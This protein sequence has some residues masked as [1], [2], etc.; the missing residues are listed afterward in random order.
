MSFSARLPAAVAFA[1][2]LAAALASGCQTAFDLER[3]RGLFEREEAPPVPVLV[4][5]PEPTL[6]APEGL[7]ATTG[8][9]RRV[10]LRWDPVLDGDVAGYVVERAPGDE[11]PFERVAV[12]PGRFQTAWVDRGSDLA[13]KPDRPTGGTQGLGD[14]ERFTYRVRAFDRQGALAA[15]SPAV[16]V[17]TAPPPAPPE[18]VH[19]YSHL[20]R[21]VAVAW[22]PS[23]DPTTAGYVI[24]RSPT[25]RGDFLPVGR[26]EGRYRTTF[27]DRN[28]G[29]L[30]VFYYRVASVNEA[31]AEGPPS[32]AERGVTKPVPLPPAGVHLHTREVGRNVLGWRPNVESDLAG[33]RL[34]RRREGTEAFQEVASLPADATEAEDRGVAAGERVAYAVMAFDRDGLESAPS[35]PL[36]VESLGFG[37]QAEVE[38]GDVHLRWDPAAQAPFA[39]TRILLEGLRTRELGRVA[40]EGFVDRRPPPGRRRYRLIGVRPD[41]RESPL[42]AVVEV[43]VPEPAEAD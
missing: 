36:V 38:G 37:L 9:L 17:A 26:V 21:R 5:A 33:Y 31:G 1:A 20:P 19:V 34:L 3:A 14:G 35:D 40:S 8:E 29:D 13:A 27:E 25:V 15:P 28:L 18:A 6:P 2:A 10:P 41:G 4:E 30:R 12:L 24:L 39:E 7:R 23:P 43:E 16:T 42:S 32:P 22:E 11:G